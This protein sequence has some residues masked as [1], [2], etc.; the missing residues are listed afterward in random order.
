MS[1]PFRGRD[2]DFEVSLPCGVKSPRKVDYQR[3]SD[4]VPDPQKAR[5]VNDPDQCKVSFVKAD[6]PVVFCNYTVPLRARRPKGTTPP[7]LRRWALPSGPLTKKA[8]DD[9]CLKIVAGKFRKKG[10]GCTPKI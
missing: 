4:L 5:L 3:I 10:G 6:K 2:I 8:L 1:A 9:R 7:A